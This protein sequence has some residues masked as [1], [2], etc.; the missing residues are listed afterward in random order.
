MQDAHFNER[1]HS[2]SQGVIL[3]K[4]LI[5]WVAGNYICRRRKERRGR[6]EERR[7]RET[8]N[9]LAE[10][11]TEGEEEPEPSGEEQYNGAGDEGSRAVM[12]TTGS[13][14]TKT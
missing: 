9:N 5:K 7:K 13:E 10:E 3:P 6:Q 2:A 8:S 1:M 14:D 12:A 11:Q 4:F